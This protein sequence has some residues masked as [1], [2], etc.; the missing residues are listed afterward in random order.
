MRCR[1]DFIRYA[2]PLGF[3]AKNE[4]YYSRIIKRRIRE[5]VAV[6]TTPKA[7]KKELSFVRLIPI[8]KLH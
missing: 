5:F 1:N 8:S 4:K 7:Y 6:T 3:N 2:L